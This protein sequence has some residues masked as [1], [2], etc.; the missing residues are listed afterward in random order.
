ME[1]VETVRE[2]SHLSRRAFLVGAASMVGVALLAACGGGAS[3]AA[4]S[5]A[6]G[7]AATVGGTVAAGSGK[8][9]NLRWSMWSAT[10]A[11]VDQWQELA[12]DITK[13]QPNIKVT[14][15]TAAF[16]DYWDKLQT[17]LASQTEPD[18]IA[19]QSLRM[20]PFA[21]RKALRPLKPYIDK[22]PGVKF[23][24]FF[25]SIEDGLSFKGEVYG[26]GYDL[27]PIILYYNKD[28]FDAAGVPVP[29]ATQL[30]T[31]DQ[32]RDTAKKL[33]KPEAGQYGLVVQPNF[34]NVVPWLWSNGGDY[35]NAEE[36]TCTLD[37]PD[38]LAAL[39]FLTGLITKDKVGAPIT[40]LANANF[41]SES[42]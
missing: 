41:A 29:S 5:G 6:N 13:A 40:D 18:L 19:M 31:W 26:F 1:T 14:F 2:R 37:A 7:A 38:S 32:F 4:S 15:E 25:K 34:D 20:P 21:V 17:Q 10:Q 8:Q 30:M 3:P 16:A 24:D 12:A 22:D 11:E 9:A 27:G 39:E 33:T 23:A 36:T 28:L 42:L 35:M